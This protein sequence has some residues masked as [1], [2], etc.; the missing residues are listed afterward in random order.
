MQKSNGVGRSLKIG[1]VGSGR[2]ANRFVPESK[3]VSDLTVEGVFGIHE[4][5]VK[6]FAKKHQLSF[7]STDYADFL[8]NVDAVYIASPHETHYSYAKEALLSG[9]H[10]LCEKPMTL[11]VAEAAELFS[12]AKEKNL[13][14]ME[15]IKTA[16]CPG[17][18][19][20]VSLA[21]SG[22]IGEIKSV[23]AA[24]TKLVPHN[25]REMQAEHAGGSV[26]ELATYP[27]YAIFKLLGSDYKDVRFVSCMKNGVDIFTKIDFVYEG[28][29]ASAKVGLGVKTEG[30]LVIS[31]TRGYVYVPA[32][33]WKTEYFEMR[34][35]NVSETEKYFY[36]F[37]GEGLRYEMVEFLERIG[38]L[39]DDDNQLDI[40]VVE[41]IEKYRIGP[42]Q[43]I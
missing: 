27:L 21:K 19:R 35:E 8:A 18:K 36:K 32:P 33:W 43:Q 34:F 22:K 15:A 30:D 28:A 12:L 5:S 6:A 2:I 41:A 23:D 38:T 3:F 13:V 7:Y 11:C 17:F 31:G 24:F 14:F 37:A 40:A 29:V 4:D 16:Y 9:K 10:V 1:I 26:T 39:F 25:V 20:L 42:V